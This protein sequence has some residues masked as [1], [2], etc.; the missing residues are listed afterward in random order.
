MISLGGQRRRVRAFICGMDGHNPSR[1]AFV[2]DS[3]IWGLHTNDG[4][5]SLYRYR[6]AARRLI[7]GRAPFAFGTCAPF[8]TNAA[9]VV[10]NDVPE[11]GIPW[12]LQR[13][14]GLPITPFKSN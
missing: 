5:G 11:L 9:Y 2:S 14:T 1:P 10:Q 13:V 3:L 4:N 6:L 7:T 8:Q 12:T